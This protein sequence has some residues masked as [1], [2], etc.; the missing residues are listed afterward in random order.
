MLE[1]KPLNRGLCPGAGTVLRARAARGGS[2]QSSG[3]STGSPEGVQSRGHSWD[4][5][6]GMSPAAAASNHHLRFWGPNL[7]GQ[8]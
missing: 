3:D 5:A 6:L 8:C 2:T 4:C 7:C 1:K